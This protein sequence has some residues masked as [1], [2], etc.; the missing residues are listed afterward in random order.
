MTHEVYEKHLKEEIRCVQGLGSGAKYWVINHRPHDKLWS[1]DLLTKIKGV[2]PM[3]AGAL[4]DH[5]IETIFE[6]QV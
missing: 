5:G 6:L 4:A 2:G 3:L 1:G